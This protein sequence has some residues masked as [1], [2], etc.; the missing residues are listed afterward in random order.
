MEIRISQL[1][2][3]KR[4]D[5]CPLKRSQA[6]KLRM[7]K[8][9]TGYGEESDILMSSILP[10]ASLCLG[11]KMLIAASLVMPKVLYKKISTCNIDCLAAAA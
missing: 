11:M 7:E 6:V 8:L 10:D 4:C 5:S 2:F 3:M 9:H 1:S